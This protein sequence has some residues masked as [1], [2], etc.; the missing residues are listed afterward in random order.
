MS[1]LVKNICYKTAGTSIF[2]VRRC[3]VFV[4]GRED[5]THYVFVSECATVHNNKKRQ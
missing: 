1:K 2:A 3:H 5:N 4:S